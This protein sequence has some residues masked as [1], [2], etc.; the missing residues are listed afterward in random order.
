MRRVKRKE[1]EELT[2]SDDRADHDNE[3]ESEQAVARGPGGP[4]PRETGAQHSKISAHFLPPGKEKGK[5]KFK[6]D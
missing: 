1:D 4:D 2:I 3:Q 6:N 5:Q